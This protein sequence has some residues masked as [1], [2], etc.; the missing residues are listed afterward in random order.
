[1]RPRLFAGA[2]WRALDHHRGRPLAKAAAARPQPKTSG[3][4]DN[5]DQEK[6]GRQTMAVVKNFIFTSF[7]G[8]EMRLRMRFELDAFKR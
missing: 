7:S 6:K 1:M 3:Q 8:N 4:D 5:E 2:F